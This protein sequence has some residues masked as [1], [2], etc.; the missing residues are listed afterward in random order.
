MSCSVS[1]FLL[2]LTSDATTDNSTPSETVF[3][4]DAAL[5]FWAIVKFGQGELVRGSSMGQKRTTITCALVPI[6]HSF[7]ALTVSN[8]ADAFIFMLGSDF[9]DVEGWIQTGGPVSFQGLGDLA[10]LSVAKILT[11][12]GE[13]LE[14]MSWGL[15]QKFRHVL[16][17]LSRE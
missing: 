6:E 4:F 3:T 16:T 10:E 2:L 12:F 14:N 1:R 13:K 5:T 17:N 7:R 8:P 9:D 15:A 11:T